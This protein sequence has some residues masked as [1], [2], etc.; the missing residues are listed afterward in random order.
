MEYDPKMLKD[1]GKE[2]LD[3][4]YGSAM[5]NL[6]NSAM[7]PDVAVRKYIRQIKKDQLYIFDSQQI[8]HI[9]ALKGKNM[10]EYEEFLLNYQEMQANSMKEHFQQYGINI[11]DYW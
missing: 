5:T 2:K 11:E 6:M 9:V 10:K 4:I 1:I 7:S 3:E 8:K